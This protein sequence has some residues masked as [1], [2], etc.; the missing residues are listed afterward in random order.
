MAEP[1][2][3]RAT[4]YFR[5]LQREHGYSDPENMVQAKWDMRAV[6]DDLEDDKNL[7]KLMMFFMDTSDDKSFRFFFRHYH[8]YYETMLS[9]IEDR[10]HVKYL[11]QKTLKDQIG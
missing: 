9:V 4:K 1:N 3:V 5:R 10:A 6:M 7:K 8:E 11:K 2:Y